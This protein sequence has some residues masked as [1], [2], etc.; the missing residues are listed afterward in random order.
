MKVFVW[1][2]VEMWRQVCQYDITRRRPEPLAAN[3][4]VPAVCQ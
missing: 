2:Q 4:Y 3:G 1:N